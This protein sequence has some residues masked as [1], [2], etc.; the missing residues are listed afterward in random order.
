MNTGHRHLSTVS[1]GVALAAFSAVAADV[2]YTWQA[3]DG[4]WDGNATDRAHWACSSADRLDYPQNNS[5][6]AVVPQNV[7]ARITIDV[8]HVSGKWEKTFRRI[9]KNVRKY[10]HGCKLRLLT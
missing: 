3:V 7:R 5:C 4:V 6:K 8:S 9:F 1:L 10:L 2:T